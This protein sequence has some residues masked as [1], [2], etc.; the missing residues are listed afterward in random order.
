MSDPISLIVGLGN[1]GAE[2][3]ATRHNV[4]FWFVDELARIGGSNF[5]NNAKFS[6]EYADV[7]ING[8]RVRLIKPTTY[9]NLSG[10][11]VVATAQFYRITAAQ[12]LVAHDE[13][14]LPLGDF[15]LKRGGGHGGH[16]GL[17]DIINKLGTN[18]FV[19]L[20]MGV[21]HPGTKERVTGHVLGR[22]SADDREVIEAA[23]AR[24]LNDIDDLLAGNV[25]EVM[26]KVNRKPKAKKVASAN[27][28]EASAP[29]KN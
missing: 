7:S 6:A 17:R 3:A 18:E 14:D 10:Q 23:T 2:Y 4:G 15:R 11:A 12:I 22:A 9:V 28:D 13:I 8:R 27:A 5:R 1:P 21:G 25:A 29:T 24:V 16:N 19:R 20:R 26:N